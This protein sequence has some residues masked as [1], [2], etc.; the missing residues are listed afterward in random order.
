V[1]AQADDR[2][3]A[4]HRVLE[5]LGFRCEARLIEADWLKDEWS[6]LRVFAV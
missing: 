5:R 6:T 1:Y 2:N 4:V 3:F